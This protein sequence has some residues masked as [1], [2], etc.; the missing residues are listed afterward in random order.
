MVCCFSQAMNIGTNHMIRSTINSWNNWFV[1]LKAKDEIAG[2]L[3]GYLWLLI[4][5]PVKDAIILVDILYMDILKKIF[6]PLVFVSSKD[7]LWKKDSPSHDCQRSSSF[8]ASLARSRVQL[9][10]PTSSL[11]TWLDFFLEILEPIW[12]SCF[13]S[14]ARSPVLVNTAT[15]SLLHWRYV[16]SLGCNCF[17]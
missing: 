10:S 11:L 6:W 17:W 7:I 1:V 14:R 2:I 3:S 15:P 9:N 16:L 8:A 13:C 4:C 12:S 5:L